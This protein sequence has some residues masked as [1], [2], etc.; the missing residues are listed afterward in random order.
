M[1]LAITHT[2]TDNIA[3]WT[4]ADLD[5]EIAAGNFPVGTVLADIVLPSDWNAQHT[6]TGTVSD[7]QLGTGINANK[8]ADGSVSNTEFQYLDGVTSA[9]QTQIDSKQATGNYITALTGEV[10]ASGPGSVAA[11]VTNSAVIGKVLTGFSALAGVV[12]A[13]DTI[14]QAIN[15]IVG[16]IASVVSGYIPYTGGTSNV[17]LGAHNLTVDTSTLFV[18]ASTH[19][20]GIGNTSPS[21]LLHASGTS[22]GQ[23]ATWSENLDLGGYSQITSHANNSY[24]TLFNVGNTAQTGIGTAFLAN[25]SFLLSA[26]SNGL[27]IME[28]TAGVPIKFFNGGPNTGNEVMRIEATTNNLCIAT[29]SSPTGEKLYVAGDI[30]TDNNHY[31]QAGYDYGFKLS[32]GVGIFIR[33]TTGYNKTL[34]QGGYAGGL[35]LKSLSSGASTVDIRDDTTAALEITS[36]TQGFLPPRMTTTQRNAISSPAQGLMLFDTTTATMWVYNGT[37]WLEQ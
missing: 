10:T 14:L 35:R 20:V 33:N 29:T 37:S 26:T 5:A 28:Q 36:T 34:L 27:N 15:K 16:N 7:A 22:S 4:Q 24:L 13:T 9:I 17:D 25:S 1:T 3:D 32:G 18:N 30:S 8:L 19:R 2:K 11:T 31:V 21:Y 6:L 12:A 23:V